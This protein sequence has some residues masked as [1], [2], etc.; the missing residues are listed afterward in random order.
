MHARA[1][2]LTQSRTVQKGGSNP[3]TPGKSHP[4]CKSSPASS[5]VCDWAEN[6]AC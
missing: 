6:L 4:V 3:Q 2:V 1:I 5:P